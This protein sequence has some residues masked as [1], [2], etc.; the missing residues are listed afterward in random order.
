MSLQDGHWSER[1]VFATYCC[2]TPCTPLFAK[3]WKEMSSWLALSVM[4][5]SVTPGSSFQSSRPVIALRRFTI[6][7]RSCWMFPVSDSGRLLWST[8]MLLTWLCTPARV[9][10]GVFFQSG[11]PVIALIRL[12]MPERSVGILPASAC[13]A[14]FWSTD[15]KSVVEGKSV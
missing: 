9:V 14:W 8:V 11:I 6:Q 1:D 15:R 7:E 3:A 5:W 13:G 2:P 4:S 10:G 12:T